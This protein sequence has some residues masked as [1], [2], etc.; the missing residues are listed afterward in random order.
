[1][2]M[3]GTE[4]MVGA[5][6]LVQYC[7]VSYLI[8]GCPTAHSLELLPS[9][10]N[11]RKRLPDITGRRAVAPR[12][13]LKQCRNSEGGCGHYVKK[14]LC[15]TAGQVSETILFF[16]LSSQSAPL[17]ISG[18]IRDTFQCWGGFTPSHWP[19]KQGSF[20]FLSQPMTTNAGLYTDLHR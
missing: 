3:P 4:R 18:N 12:S 6:S 5:G 19:P 20:F 2:P 8:F 13:A 17:G 14:E 11:T 7:K 16:V 15:C 1:M 9:S 10:Y